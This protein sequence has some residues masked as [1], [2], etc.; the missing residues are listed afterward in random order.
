MKRL[1]VLI[2]GG[3]SNLQALIDAIKEKEINAEILA[4]FSNKK[5]A[6]GLKRAEVNGIET[7]IIHNDYSLI[8]AYN[9]DGII[10]AGYLK[11][12]PKEFVDKY[13]NKIINIHPSLIPSFCG[14]G[15]YG[16]KVHEAVL[17]YGVKIS[18]A[19][20]HFV[21]S[22]PDEGPV[23]M[24]KVV[25]VKVD[26]TV[27]SLS[28]RVLEVEH[29]IIKETVKLYCEDSLIVNGRIVEIKKGTNK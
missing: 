11:I 18:G 3:G 5:D 12:I 7:G 19:T 16:S 17:N 13:K 14:K 20:T 22:I 10:L 24:Q 28:S 2:S 8:D 29:E 25:E 9:P 4:V 23:I 6:Y 21:S 15:Y 27:D 1:V 26:D